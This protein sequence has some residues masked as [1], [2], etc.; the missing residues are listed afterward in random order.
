[1]VTSPR[2]HHAF[3]APKLSATPWMITFADLLTLLVAFFVLRLSMVSFNTDLAR[4]SLQKLNGETEVKSITP[5]PINVA[6]EVLPAEAAKP[7][8][9]SEFVTTL[10]RVVGS[11]AGAAGEHLE[12][13]V[14]HERTTPRILIGEEAFSSGSDELSFHAQEVITRVSWVLSQRNNEGAKSRI[15]VIGHTDDEVVNSARFP[16]N[17]ELSTARALA[18]AR[19]MID[20][21]VDPRTVSVSGYADRL[22]LLPNSSRLNRQLNR[23]VEILITLVRQPN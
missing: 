5:A 1:M 9:E 19:Q 16:S 3:D 8:I 21:G 23:R 4:H 14:A 13:S 15:T 20:A 10:R 11:E 17:W 6:K 22:P 18:V 12:V 7:T 2:Q